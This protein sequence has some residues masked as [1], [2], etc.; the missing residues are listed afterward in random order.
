MITI[1]G[2]DY[3]ISWRFFK[4]EMSFFIPC[5]DASAAE[6]VI[7][8]ELKE[9]GFPGHILKVTEAGV[10]GLRVWRL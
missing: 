9:Q 5:S 6:E 8:A 2:V 10:M 7:S 3:D 4:P 1:E